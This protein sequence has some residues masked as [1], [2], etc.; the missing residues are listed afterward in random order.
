MLRHGVCAPTV[1][2]AVKAAAAGSSGTTSFETSHDDD[3]AP[4]IL[5]AH[6]TPSAREEWA[7]VPGRV[8]DGI[9]ATSVADLAVLVRGERITKIVH[10]SEIPASSTR[11]EMP[12][13]TAIPGLIDAHVHLTAAMGPAF[14]AAGVTTVRDTG[15]GLHWV[16]ARRALHATCEGARAG[17]S[18]VCCGNALDFD[19]PS[20]PLWHYMVREHSSAEALERSVTEHCDAGVDQIKLYARL[21]AALLA[22]GAQ[23]AKAH[24]RFVLAHLGGSKAFGHATFRDGVVAGIDEFEHLVGLETPWQLEA[25]DAEMTAE[26]EEL[27]ASGLIINPTLLVWKRFGGI[28]DHALQHDSRKRWVTLDCYS[29]THFPDHVDF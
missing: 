29:N 2:H 6:E 14:L 18:I 28:L 19:T 1:A 26:V 17:P 24:G 7:L 15:N 22:T 9:S 10:V 27:L 5:A 11:V 23:V 4:T 12:G 3:P 21:D 20:P 8:W 16:L 13:C 25:E